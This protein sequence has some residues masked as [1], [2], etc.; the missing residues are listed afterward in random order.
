M[1]QSFYQAKPDMKPQLTRSTELLAA[2]AR[3]PSIALRNQIV[4]LNAG[5]VRKIA[6]RISFQAVESFEDLE[7]IGFIGLIR[8]IERFNLRKGCAFSSFAVPYIRGEILN[9]LRDKSNIV[10][11][12]R[13]WQELHQRSK[14]VRRELALFL[15][16][17]PSDREL[18]EALDVSLTEWQEC[19]VAVQNRRLVSLDTAITPD[20]EGK[21]TLEETLPDLDDQTRRDWQEERWHLQSALNQ[22]EEKTQAAI[23]YVFLRDLSRKEAAKYIGVSTVTVSR[24]LQKGVA[25]LELLLEPAIAV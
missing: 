9:F 14:R 17:Q 15:G 11:I 1:F 20:S 23:E 8:A 3:T 18:A 7:Q 12:P 6:R 24:H 19:K 21:V 4:Q 10:R 22:L 16:R 13:R 25:Q 5:L 2:Y